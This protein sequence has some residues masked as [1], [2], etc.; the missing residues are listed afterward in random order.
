MTQ[1][2]HPFQAPLLCATHAVALLGTVIL[3]PLVWRA[4]K[5]AA[6]VRYDALT[7][8][9]TLLARRRVTA[10]ALAP[11]LSPAG[12]LLPLLLQSM[13]EDWYVDTRRMGCAALAQVFR[14]AGAALDDAARRSVY[15]E[16]NKRM[17]DSSNA[18]RVAAAAAIVAFAEDALPHDYCDT[19]SG[20]FVAALLIHLD[21]GSAE[22]QAAVQ[23]ALCALA[24]KKGAVV[25]AEIGKV[26]AQFRSKFLLDQ[27]LERC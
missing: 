25:R 20:Y 5:T 23:A 15:P 10:G 26:H 19:N 24:A 14:V 22:V 2:L 27:V 3:P 6:A 16:L 21:D 13:D 4:G 9:H 11:Q 8:L 12:Q 17:D 18:V 1:T 7:A